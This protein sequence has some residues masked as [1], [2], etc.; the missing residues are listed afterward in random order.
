M[1]ASE[2]AAPACLYNLAVSLGFTELRARRESRPT[3]AVIRLFGWPI[4]V[5][6]FGFAGPRTDYAQPPMG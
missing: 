3:D 6:E 4:S 5:V 1:P 2:G